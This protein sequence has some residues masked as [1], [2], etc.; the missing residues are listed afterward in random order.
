MNKQLDIIS[1]IQNV[2]ALDTIT[3]KVIAIDGPGGAGKITLARLLS[4]ELVHG[5]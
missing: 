5:G 1:A 3:T 2:H 4:E